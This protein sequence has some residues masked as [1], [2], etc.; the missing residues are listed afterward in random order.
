[1]SIEERVVIKDLREEGHGS[2]QI[3]S[4]LVEYYGDKA[5]SYLD[6]SDWVRLFPMGR[7]SFEDWRNN[8]RPPD[9]QA[10]FRIEGALEASPNASV[11]EFAQTADIAP[12]TVFSVFTQVLHLEFRDWRWILH[13]LSSSQKEQEDNLLFRCM[14]RF[15]G[16]RTGTGRNSPLVMSPG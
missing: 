16:H 10:H 8:A 9:F 3:H 2:S 14:P 1:M 5:L 7:E 6:V 13:K 15:G 4:E 12:S 11:R